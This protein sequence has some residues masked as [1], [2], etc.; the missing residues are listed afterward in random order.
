ME[1]TLVTKLNQAISDLDVLKNQY[2]ALVTEA[3]NARD[4]ANKWANSSPPN[5]T[6]AQK[7][8]DIAESKESQAK[9]KLVEIGLKEAQIQEIKDAINS[10]PAAKAEMERIE[11]KAKT[12]RI[13]IYSV[14]GVVLLII[15]IVVIKKFW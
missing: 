6:E 2:S 8:I 11:Q 15:I 12:Q 5:A 7:N 14:I 3:G 1:N 4:L 10:D 9:S 13:I